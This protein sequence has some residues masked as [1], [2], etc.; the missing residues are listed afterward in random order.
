M[1]FDG[2]I[3]SRRSIKSFKKK[4]A[5]WKQAMYAIDMAL[6]APMAGNINTFKFIIVENSNTINRIAELCDQLWINQAGIV[7]VVCSDNTPLEKLYGE[8][9]KIYSRQQAGAAIENLLLKVTD[10]GLSAC[11]VGAFT[12]ELLEQL[13]K[14][15]EHMRIEAV[16]PIGYASEKPGYKRKHSLENSIYWEAWG[17]NKRPTIFSEKRTDMPKTTGIIKK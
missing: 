10:M 7:V 13:L 6:K 16:I 5:D 1:D 9:G 2:I 15:P 11:W 12:D 17:T 14:I 4:K 8:R 3:E